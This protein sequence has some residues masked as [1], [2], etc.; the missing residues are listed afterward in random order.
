MKLAARRPQNGTLA[1][2]LSRELEVRQT[3]SGRRYPVLGPPAIE[4]LRL[5][6]LESSPL[7]GTE[8]DEET[9]QPLT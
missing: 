9:S 2:D 3:G 1:H 8:R 7:R 5:G 4:T 6:E